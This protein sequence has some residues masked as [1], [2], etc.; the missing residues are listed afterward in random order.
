MYVYQ[1]QPETARITSEN[2]VGDILL[3]TSWILKVRVKEKNNFSGNILALVQTVCNKAEILP[4]KLF[5]SSTQILSFKVFLEV[6]FST[7]WLYHSL[8]AKYSP[9]FFLITS[10]PYY[11]CS[12]FHNQSLYQ[13]YIVRHVRNPFLQ[14]ISTLDN[15]SKVSCL[16]HFHAFQTC[17][18]LGGRSRPGPCKLV[19][20]GELTWL[21]KLSN[22]SISGIIWFI[23]KKYYNCIFSQLV[24]SFVINA[25]VINPRPIYR[26]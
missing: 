20:P 13:S 22:K 1:L 7:V 6:F 18:T 5:L 4:I 16:G 26:K 11:I 17:T 24:L 21:H 9:Y 14:D 3:K 8:S 12:T 2:K 19:P 23:V 25:V 15:I 10:C